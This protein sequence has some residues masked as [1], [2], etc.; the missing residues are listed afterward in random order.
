MSDT[1]HHHAPAGSEPT[2]GDGVNY[3]GIVWFVAILA[4][5]TFACQLLMWGMFAFMDRQAAKDDAAH[6]SLA[7]AYGNES[8]DCQPV[9]TPTGGEK[10]G[11][12]PCIMHDGQV[13]PGRTM[14]QPNLMADDPL[15]LKVFR[16]KEDQILEHYD[17]MDKNAGTYRI[18]IERAKELLIQRG[19]PG[20]TVTPAAAAPAVKK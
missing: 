14:P 6:P 19:I 1:S 7:L 2:E 12:M 13:A 10:I 9:P 3:R 20:G 8:S 5:T 16:A 17:V 15:G 4:G 18:P 11:R